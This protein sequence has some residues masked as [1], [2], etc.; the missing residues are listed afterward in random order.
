M[1]EKIP[2]KNL[3]A[4][5]PGGKT[6]T[7]VLPA[8]NQ[9]PVQP[10]AAPVA[11]PVAPALFG[12][13]KGGGKK[14][15]DGLVAGSP[16]AIEA[17]KKKN[18]KRMRDARAAKAEKNPVAAL[19]SAAVPPPNPPV[20]VAGDSW[21]GV[22]PVAAVAGA[23]AP[24]AA[25][26]FVAWSEKLLARPIKL[27][28]KII[29]RLRVSALMQRVRKLNLKPE[30]EKEVEKK[31]RYK[32]EVITDFNTALA[33]CA[34]IELNKRNVGGAQHGHWLDVALTG[35]ELVAVHL[36][37]VDYLEKIIGEN[38]AASAAQPE[39]V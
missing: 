13:H 7:P 24:V 6:A 4:A 17:D 11:A 21:A 19:P 26:L 2:A 27:L 34:A 38:A 9:S 23:A 22:A 37:A 20:P 39:K 14:R 8:V 18:A 12:G 35:G 10:G 1:S 25:P 3:P 28:T 32:E 29:D 36:E 5:N 31:F 15:A 30:Q 33:N 16:E